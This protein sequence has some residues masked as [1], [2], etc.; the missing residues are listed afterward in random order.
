MYSC[1]LLKMRLEINVGSDIVLLRFTEAP[2]LTFF[3]RLFHVQKTGP[4]V[5][6]FIYY[7]YS[8]N[9]FYPLPGHARII[10]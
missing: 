6:F 9:Y 1:V 3:W 4:G 2:F 7:H 10:R 5:L 8:F